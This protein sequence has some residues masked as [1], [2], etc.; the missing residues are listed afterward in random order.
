MRKQIPDIIKGGIVAIAIFVA[1]ALVPHTIQRITTADIT[2]TDCLFK[3][4]SQYW[5]M[6]GF[7]SIIVYTA[8]RTAYDYGYIHS[9]LDFECVNERS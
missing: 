6:N 9:T 1:H 7:A 2:K 5:S 3:V 4:Y 8:I